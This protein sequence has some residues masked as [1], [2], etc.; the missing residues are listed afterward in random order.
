MSK[1]P[2]SSN[3]SDFAELKLELLKAPSI[4][5]R[6]D[7][8]EKWLKE[9][10]E[11]NCSFK[12]LQELLGDQPSNDNCFVI[13]AWLKKSANN[14]NAEELAQAGLKIPSFRY[15]HVLI[16]SWLNKGNDF[17]EIEVFLA[18]EEKCNDDDIKKLS[19]ISY[20][21]HK[22]FIEKSHETYQVAIEKSK[23]H[24]KAYQIASSISLR[25]SVGVEI[26][27]VSSKLAELSDLEDRRWSLVDDGSLEA[28]E[29]KPFT[30]E[31]VSPIINTPEQI[32]NIIT[33]CSTAAEKWGADTNPSCG[34]HIHVGLFPKSI[35]DTTK[36]LPGSLEL[37]KQVL[38][39]YAILEEMGLKFPPRHYPMKSVKADNGDATYDKLK[40][41]QKA[42][43][44]DEILPLI[45]SDRTTDPVN[46]HSL[47]KH[48]TIEFR[49]HSGTIDANNILSWMKFINE[50]MLV[51]Q[52]MLDKNDGRA[53][54]TGNTKNLL[55]NQLLSKQNPNLSDE[56]KQMHEMLQELQNSNSCVVGSKVATSSP[57]NTEASQITTSP[58]ASPPSADVNTNRNT[59]QRLLRSPG[60][61][62]SIQ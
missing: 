22:N 7:A 45:N 23:G 62:C 27:F 3:Q 9:K 8:L 30:K 58:A 25:C 37:I 32:Q 50:L 29:S 57:L 31:L 14:C 60:N 17:Q 1:N 18:S 24:Q 42:S 51:S 21:E 36:V 40:K 44:V 46:L 19:Q 56:L 41:I 10:E 38:I 4:Y 47:F 39:N 2:V 55:K 5:D 59:G 6:N 26:E 52:S 33:T 15:R 35:R 61:N 13:K 20:P 16:E 28:T 43:G 11:N 49:A 12:D 34:L 48:G 54:L 53:T